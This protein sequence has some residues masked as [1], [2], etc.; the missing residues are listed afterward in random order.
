MS[1]RALALALVTTTASADTASNAL[2]SAAVIGAVVVVVAAMVTTGVFAC[3]WVVLWRR[4]KGNPATCDT[5]D[6][7]Q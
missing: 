5:P 7:E 3:Y 6:D 1:A 2:A 4:A